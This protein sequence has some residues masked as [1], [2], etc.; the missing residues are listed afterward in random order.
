MGPGGRSSSSSGRFPRMLHLSY[1]LHTHKQ[2]NDYFGT[3]GY[4]E[5]PPDPPVGVDRRRVP[6]VG[7]RRGHP[8]HALHALHTSPGRVLGLW[9]VLGYSG[10]YSGVPQYRFFSFSG[11]AVGCL[12]SRRR[13]RVQDTTTHPAVC[14][15]KLGYFFLIFFHGRNVYM[16][17]YILGWAIWVRAPN[18]HGPAQGRVVSSSPV[19]YNVLGDPPDLFDFC[20]RD[21]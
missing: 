6:G 2:K 3:P 11:D 15:E 1:I 13:V 17:Y 9:G 19:E 4:P 12:R 8:G 14:S 7:R 10:G 18:P 21:V 5:Y 20:P 16:F